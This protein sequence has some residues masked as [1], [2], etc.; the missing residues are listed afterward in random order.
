MAKRKSRA[1]LECSRLQIL[2]DNIKRRWAYNAVL[3]FPE[4]QQR[5]IE[6]WEQ[7]IKEINAER[8]YTEEMKAQAVAKCE[9]KIREIRQSI[10]FFYEL[11]PWVQR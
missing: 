11:H 9:A 3:D 6:R 1:V 2:K 8:F 4:N 5:N 7:K 10:D